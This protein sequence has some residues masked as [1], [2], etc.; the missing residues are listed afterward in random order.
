MR[1]RR[2]IIII[3]SL[4][5]IVTA[6]GKDAV[7]DRLVSTDHIG[8]NKVYT[9]RKPILGKD[10]YY[11]GVLDTYTGSHLSVWAIYGRNSDKEEWTPVYNFSSSKAGSFVCPADYRQV[12]IGWSKSE[13]EQGVTISYRIAEE[14]FDHS[15]LY[16]SSSH[17]SDDN[18]GRIGTPFATIGKA[19]SM[20]PATV[21]LRCGDIFYEQVRCD[22]INIA[23]YS[24]GKK[25]LICGLKILPAKAWQPVETTASG[26]KI[27]KVDLALDKHAYRGLRHGGK[28]FLNN[29]G[30][31]V[32][33]G[34]TLHDSKLCDSKRVKS[35]DDL[36]KSDARNFDFFQPLNPQAKTTP[37]GNFDNVYVCYNGNPD[38]D[39]GVISGCNGMEIGDGRVDSVE[40][41]YWGR[42]GIAG[43]SNVSITGCD[44]DGIGGMVEINY[45]VFVCLGNGI[46][47]YITHD[48][49]R[50]S[51]VTGCH[52]KHCYDAGLTVQGSEPDPTDMR[53]LEAHDVTFTGNVIENCC[54]SFEEFIIGNNPTDV[55]Y[56]C[57]FADNVSRQPG[58][59]TGFRYSDGRYKRSHFLACALARPTGMMYSHNE[60]Y[61]G[62][63]LCVNDKQGKYVQGLWTGNTCHIR[64]G[65]DLLGNYIGTADVITVPTHKGK[66][67]TLKAATDAAIARY[68][69]LTGDTTTE[70]I[71]T[72]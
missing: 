39:F 36:K 16:V 38:D 44:I 64:R 20:R 72:D 68:R 46:E 11:R 51:H 12:K 2:I 62:N 17:G 52:V 41:R 22:G 49:I 47:F 66:Y 71:V 28:N 33:L 45:P 13:I 14:T 50:N 27:W 23:P 8:G 19:I 7:A 60:C 54:Q 10:K 32:R 37:A 53:P 30:G 3:I 69:E 34:A 57:I 24:T 42:H 9:S 67:A 18:D 63:F 61:D 25:P 58:I 70:F 35:Y 15:N 56:G 5:S 40:I 31:F 4:L 21:R 48:G 55:Y 1:I 59:D 43:K 65:Q 29:I 6:V 26:M